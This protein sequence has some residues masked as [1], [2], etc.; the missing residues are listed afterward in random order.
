MASKKNRVAKKTPQLFL[1][2]GYGIARSI[3]GVKLAQ[4]Q[5]QCKTE[6]FIWGELCSDLRPNPS[7]LEVEVFFLGK[8]FLGPFSKK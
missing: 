6:I 5:T 7:E 4:P 1:D 2:D 3:L 8:F